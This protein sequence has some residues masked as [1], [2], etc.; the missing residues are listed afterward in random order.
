[1]S[2]NR[3]FDYKCRSLA[4]CTLHFHR[5]AMPFGHNIIRQTQPQ[6]RSFAHGFGR[7]KGLEDFGFR[8][9]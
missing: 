3:Q 8:S 1:M 9:V 5:P 2:L 7:K 6:T 4:L